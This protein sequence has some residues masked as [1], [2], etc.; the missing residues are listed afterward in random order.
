MPCFLV[1]F[2]LKCQR[3]VSVRL[4]DGTFPSDN[5]RTT[6]ERVRDY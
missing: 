2:G 1:T 4:C 5:T 3:V 6:L